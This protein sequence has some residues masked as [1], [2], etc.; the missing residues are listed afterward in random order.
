MEGLYQSKLDVLQSPIASSLGSY[1]PGDFKFR[2]LNG[3]GVIDANDRT[4][5]GNPS[6]D[7]M[8]GGSIGLNFKRFNLVVD[9]GGAYGNEIFRTWGSLESP[10]QRVNYAAFK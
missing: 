8:Y 1:G 10:F 6:P 9:V 3:D 7:F 5:I 2:D 4:V